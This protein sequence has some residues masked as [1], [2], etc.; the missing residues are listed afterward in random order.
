MPEE[1]TTPDPVELTRRTFEVGNRRDFDAVVSFWRPDYV[2]DLSPMGL[3]I[4]EGAE[5]IRAFF[6]D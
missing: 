3:G 2:W 5:A 4:Y 1:S 6:E